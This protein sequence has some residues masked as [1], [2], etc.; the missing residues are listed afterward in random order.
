MCV[1]LLLLASATITEAQVSALRPPTPVEPI[2]A[3][4]DAFRTH[5]IVALSDPH[6]NV[7]LQAFLL[8]LIRLLERVRAAHIFNVWTVL[9]R[10]VELPDAVASWRMPSLAAMHGT[11]LGATDFATYSGGFGFGTRFG[12]QDGQS[13]RFL[14]KSGR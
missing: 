1:A 14:A 4:L 8:S 13:F 7:Q 10:D 9:E 12:V 5:D 6:G 11:A 2:A 3:I